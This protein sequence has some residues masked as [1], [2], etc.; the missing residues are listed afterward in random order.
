M[1]AISKMQPFRQLSW[2]IRY[3]ARLMRKWCENTTSNRT[4]SQNSTDIIENSNKQ[5]RAD[6]SF[7][8]HLTNEKSRSMMK[9]SEELEGH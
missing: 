5:A 1:S 3:M 7:S 2:Q 4:Y 9:T 6:F 8:L